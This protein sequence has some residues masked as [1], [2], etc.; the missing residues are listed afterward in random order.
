M[1]KWA[2]TAL[3]LPYHKVEGSRLAW[4]WI[5]K[6]RIWAKGS[7]W[8]GHFFTKPAI[9]SFWTLAIALRIL[10]CFWAV[11]F[12]EALLR[13][14]FFSELCNITRGTSMTVSSGRAGNWTLQL[15]M[16]IILVAA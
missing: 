12:P 3:E 9:K 15:H 11:I 8:T 14:D 5:P 16:I 4:E 13:S 6:A 10:G 2:I 7:N 1:A